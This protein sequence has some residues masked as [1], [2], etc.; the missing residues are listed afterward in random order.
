MSVNPAIKNCEIV[1]KMRILYDNFERNSLID[2]VETEEEENEE[3][4]F[5]AALLETSVMK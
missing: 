2:E 3:N 5:I 1:K 4:D